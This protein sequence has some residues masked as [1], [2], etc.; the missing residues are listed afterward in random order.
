M[1]I[2][3]S[4]NIHLHKSW[5]RFSNH[6]VWSAVIA[7]MVTAACVGLI[8]VA[9]ELLTTKSPQRPVERAEVKGGPWGPSRLLYRCMPNGPCATPEHVALD[10][11]VD[12]PAV[13][14]EVNYMKARVLSS[15]EATQGRIAVNARPGR[16]AVKVGDT[17]LVA[18]LVKNDVDIHTNRGKHLVAR[19]TRFRLTL[20]ITNGSSELPVIG[21]IAAANAAPRRLWDTIFLHSKTRFAIEYVWKSAALTN[22]AHRQ[23]TLSDELIG[24]GV[25]VGSRRADGNVSPGLA[26]KATVLFLLR[27]VPASS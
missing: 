2:I 26:N 14:N 8:Q 6:P 3:R 15:Q 11:I 13:G 23:L 9:E 25:L 4:F 12:D 20:P 27:I 19:D 16:L 22:R 10:S 24:D 18:A 7:G 1:T 17:V 5:E 21:L